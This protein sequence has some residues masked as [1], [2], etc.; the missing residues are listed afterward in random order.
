MRAEPLRSAGRQQDETVPYVPGSSD[1]VAEDPW[2]RPDAH[3]VEFHLSSVARDCG[4][5]RRSYGRR[6]SRLSGRGRKASRPSILL[7]R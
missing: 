5:N 1:P 2:G 6:P 3:R 7:S 4:L